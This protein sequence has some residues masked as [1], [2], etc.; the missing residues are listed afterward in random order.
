MSASWITVQFRCCGAVVGMDAAA[1]ALWLREDEAP[2]FNL[3]LAAADSLDSI[4]E[5]IRPGPVR[6][7]IVPTIPSMQLEAVAGL[8]AGFRGASRLARTRIARW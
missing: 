7:S 8:P 4:D 2:Q 3:P 1:Y 5:E 6:G